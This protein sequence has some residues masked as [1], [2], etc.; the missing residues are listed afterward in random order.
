[1]GE[2][3]TV[4]NKVEYT[5]VGAESSLLYSHIIQTRYVAADAVATLEGSGLAEAFKN[6]EVLTRPGTC[7]R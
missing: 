3:S 2:Y 7:S 5:S 4:V 1:M 6:Q